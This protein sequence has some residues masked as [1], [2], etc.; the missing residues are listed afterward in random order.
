MPV[1]DTAARPRATLG[2]SVSEPLPIDRDPAVDGSCPARTPVG[3]YA[4]ALRDR[5]RE[6]VRV[7]VIGEL[8]NLRPPARTRVYF[9][10]RDA[11]GALPCAMWRND[12]ERLGARTRRRWPTARR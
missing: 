9:E 11:D 4:R 6:F 12:W 5:L 2:W 10:L 3:V 1:P 7:Q 8:A